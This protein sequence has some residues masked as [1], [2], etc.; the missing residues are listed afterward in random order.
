MGRLYRQ[1]ELNP[2]ISEGGIQKLTFV[3]SAHLDASYVRS[4]QIFVIA[5]WRG[6]PW[7]GFLSSLGKLTQ[8]S[9]DSQQ[10]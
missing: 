2:G 8:S 4:L 9:L 1:T 7:Q 5:L 6:R 3:T 10:I